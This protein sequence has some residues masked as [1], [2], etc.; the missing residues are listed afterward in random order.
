MQNDIILS[1][2]QS[3]T[4]EFRATVFRA[5]ALVQGIVNT[6]SAPLKW[7]RGYYSSVC[8]KQLTMSQTL[9]LLNTQVAFVATIL[10]ADMPL[11]LRIACCGWF[12]TSVMKCK[13]RI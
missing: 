2:H 6:V 3:A 10:P 12:A 11:L 8:E 9:L 4:S 1:Q 13:K 7:L 5:T